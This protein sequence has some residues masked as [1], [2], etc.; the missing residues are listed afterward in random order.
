MKQKRI[1]VVRPDAMG[2]V[3][4]SLPMANELKNA[5]PDAEVMY[6]ASDY[7]QDLLLNNAAVK[8]VIMDCFCKNKSFSTWLKLFRLIRSE[9]F[10]VVIFPINDIAYAFM[11]WLARIPIRIGDAA[12][13]LPSLFYTHRVNRLY[14]NIWQHEVNINLRLLAPLG[15]NIKESRRYGFLTNR[16]PQPPLIQAAMKRMTQ[17][18]AIIVHTGLANGNLPIPMTLYETLIEQLLAQGYL[19]VLTGSPREADAIK[20]L[21]DY[22]G[23]SVCSVAGQTTMLTL[24]PILSMA[25]AFI[26]TTTGPLHLAAA[27][28]VPVVAILPS[29]LIK[30]TRWGPYGVPA[31]TVEPHGVC[32]K[33]CIPYTCQTREC[34]ETIRVE[35]VM[36]ALNRVQDMPQ[37]LSVK[38]YKISLQRQCIRVV[39]DALWSKSTVKN[40]APIVLVNKIR[41]IDR[42]KRLIV[43]SKMYYPPVLIQ[44]KENQ[45]LEEALDALYP[46]D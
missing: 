13:P 45:S 39:D 15:M 3:I 8:A 35:D 14:S 22:F 24:I 21:L 29:K 10:D 4:L 16:I 36:A 12:V 41:I 18:P 30:A 5:W 1:L 19:P 23:E 44:K 28:G 20:P 46:N 33:V 7:T 34:V 2:D 6:L 37:S 43:A 25:K 26:G 11:G 42:V 17:H 31:Q 38:D 27:L 40:D 9:H 32:P